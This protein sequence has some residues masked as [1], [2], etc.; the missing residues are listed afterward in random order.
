MDRENIMRQA[1]ALV[2]VLQERAPQAEALRCVPQATVD[3]L[4]RTDLIRAP[5][6][7]RFGG[8]GFDFDSS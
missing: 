5:L 1:A 4:C 3:D 2:P 8:L 7:E 6:P